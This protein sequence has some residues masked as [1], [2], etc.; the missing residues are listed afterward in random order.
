MELWG[1]IFCIPLERALRARSRGMQKIS[2]HSS[3]L[4]PLGSDHQKTCMKLTSADF[5]VEN[6]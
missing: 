6:S 1:E 4:T 5:T 2:P 3:I